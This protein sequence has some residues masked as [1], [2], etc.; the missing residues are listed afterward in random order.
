M[1]AQIV[2]T[3]IFGLGGSVVAAYIIE[4]NIMTQYDKTIE[5]PADTVSIVITAYNEEQFIRQC[6][7]SIQNQSIIQKHPEYFEIILA[8]NESTDRTAEIASKYIGYTNI[9]TIPGGKLDVRN[10]SVKYTDGNIIVSVDADTYYPEHW[11]NTLLKPMKTSDVC[12]V[13]GNIMDYSTPF[14]PGKFNSLVYTVNKIISPYRI[15]GSNSAYFKKYFY[16][17]GMFRTD[18]IDQLNVEEVFTE[19]E[20]EFGKRLS[21]FGRIVFVPNATS[22][23]LGGFRVACRKGIILNTEQCNIAGIGRTR[24]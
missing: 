9:I 4:K 16:K 20:H 8:D 11:L 1:L 14:I 5:P 3:A 2:R 18:N 6:I 24:F 17:A 12:A 15:S 22:V 7:K 13:T 21:K 10:E 19:E 23:H